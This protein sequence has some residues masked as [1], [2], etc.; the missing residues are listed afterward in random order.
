MKVLIYNKG[1][2]DEEA[3]CK[4]L[5]KNLIRHGMEK[6][7]DIEDADYIVYVTCGGVGETIDEEADELGKLCGYVKEKPTKLI[8]VGCLLTDQEWWFD[9]IKNNPNTVFIK[10]KEWG[11]NV[12]NYITGQN[13][14]ATLEERAKYRTYGGDPNNVD[15]RFTSQ[16][17]CPN[18]CSF[19]K[20]QYMDGQLKS[21]PFKATVNYLTKMIKSGTRIVELGGD[22]TAQYG[23]DLY[24]KQRLHEVIQEISK[25]EG[26]E[27]IRIKELVPGDMYP[28]LID[29]IIANPKVVSTTFQ[30]QTASDVLLSKMR[31]NYNLGQYDEYVSDILAQGKYVETLLMSGFPTE[32]YK[33]IDKTL[34]YLSDRRILTVGTSPYCDAEY[35]AS[36][37]FKQYTQKEKMERALYLARGFREINRRIYQE[38]ISKQTRLIHTEA[39]EGVYYFASA[40]PII[41]TYS[42]SEDFYGL[43]PGSIVAGPPQELCKLDEEGRSYMYVLGK[44]SA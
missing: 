20:F 38:E 26:L 44:K 40:I 21:F 2:V 31:R 24:K 34:Q 10:G 13:K 22:N 41:R 23:M 18:Y 4:T 9:E 43:A 25:V 28:E 1:C 5:E 27:W 7:E 6:T 11:I 15:I 12:C 32:T 16:K 39:A 35:I 8:I 14:K 30:L 17:G 42:T 3:K 29:E 37:K 33:D 36:H 19:C